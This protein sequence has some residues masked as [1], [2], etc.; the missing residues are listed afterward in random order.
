ME[1]RKTVFVL[2]VGLVASLAFA[3]V[4]KFMKEQG[5]E[6]EI[7]TEV[8]QECEAVSQPKEIPAQKEEIG[9]VK[10]T[11]PP[12]L[13]ETEVSEAPTE[14]PLVEEATTLE[15]PTKE[16]EAEVTQAPLKPTEAPTPQPTMAPVTPTQ[17]PQT[18]ETTE[19]AGSS[20]VQII[21]PQN[22]DVPQVTESPIVEESVHTHEFEKAIW[23]LPTCQ[24]GG[25]YNNICKICGL[26]EGVSQEPLPHETEDI[27]IQEGNCME[28]RVIRHVCKFCGVQ[29]E[30]DTRY[31]LYDEHQWGTEEVDG[32]AVEYCERCGVVK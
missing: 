16:D 1:I 10:E 8:V 12:L 9:Q 11:D 14:V 29:T 32:V 4:C 31:P 5:E 22:T 17:A 24:K 15:M 21:E 13:Q 25:Y 6:V 7:I 27:V 26:V 18:P 2:L 19:A 20:E 28:D 3:G 30:S 23:E